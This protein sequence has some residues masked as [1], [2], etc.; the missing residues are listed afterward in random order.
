ML[1]SVVPGRIVG[2]DPTPQILALARMRHTSTPLEYHQTFDGMLPF[3]GR[4]FGV[5][6]CCLSLSTV[7]DDEILR[8]ELGEVARVLRPGALVVLVDNTEGVDGSGRRV[9][10]PYS[11]SR[12]VEEYKAVFKELLDCRLRVVDEYEDLGERITAMTGRAGEE[13]L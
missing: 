13:S 6:W 4:A 10:S 3:P 1:M 11:R 12:T 2:V 9:N 8:H 7:L 5:L